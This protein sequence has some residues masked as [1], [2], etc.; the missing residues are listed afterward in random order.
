[1][2]SKPPRATRGVVHRGD[3]HT[4]RQRDSDPDAKGFGRIMRLM[5][6]IRKSR[7]AILG[8]ELAGVVAAIGNDKSSA[9][10][11][12]MA[13]GTAPGLNDW[14]AAAL[15]MGNPDDPLLLES[16]IVAVTDVVESMGAHRPYRAS[17][18]WE[19]ALAA[20]TKNKGRLYD[21]DVVEAC[22][23]MLT[24]APIPA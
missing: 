21:T 15:Q 14:M 4:Q 1:M 6:G 8:S 5:F 12:G 23:W 10:Q 7:Q 9:P 2:G 22:L 19:A 3:R 13:V 24:H 17:L 20:I 18:G 16:R 11:D